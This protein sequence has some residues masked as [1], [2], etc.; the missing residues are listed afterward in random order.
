MSKRSRSTLF[1]IEQLIVIAIFAVC[2]AACVSIL[3]VSFISARESSD[4]SGAI[5]TAESAAESFKAVSGDLDRVAAIL[6]GVR[7]SEG[8]ND[9]LIIHYDERWQAVDESDAQF[10]L[11]MIRINE[12]SPQTLI[13]VRLSVESIAGEEILSF[14][15]IAR[16]A[17]EVA[18]T[19]GG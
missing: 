1:L 10:I 14:P 17:T 9:K 19:G 2:A 8:N 4:K 7:V 6:G 3:T 5:L 16:A 13:Y 15:V 18:A 12:N 11:R